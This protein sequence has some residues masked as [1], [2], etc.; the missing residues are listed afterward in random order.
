MRP[1]PEKKI[2]VA[3]E[4]PI[5]NKVK[6]LE[7]DHET[8]ELLSMTREILKSDTDYSA[9]L[10]ANVR[11]FH[12]AIKT[13]NRLNKMESELTT[14]KSMFTDLARENAEVKDKLKYTDRIRNG[15]SEVEKGDILK[16]RAM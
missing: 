7:D 16:K 8:A 1:E 13:E 3:E 2:Q 14:M 11:S 12:H 6:N 4:T 9:S 10:A 5:Y 15:D